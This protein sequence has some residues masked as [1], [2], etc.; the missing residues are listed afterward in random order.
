LAL[1]D[2]VVQMLQHVCHMDDCGKGSA[3]SCSACTWRFLCRI[4]CR[5]V[6]SPPVLRVWQ[7]WRRR[8]I[9][10]GGKTYAAGSMADKLTEMPD[11]DGAH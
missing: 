5:W 8:E 7:G 2:G 3:R 10:P 9:L 4:W 1:D 11:R 6:A